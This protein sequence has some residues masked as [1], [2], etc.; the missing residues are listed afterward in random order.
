MARSTVFML[1]VLACS[2]KASNTGPIFWYLRSNSSICLDWAGATDQQ[3]QQTSVCMSNKSSQVFGLD[4]AAHRL[5]LG[6]AANCNDGSP[7]CVENF[8]G[9]SPTI[10]GCSDPSGKNFQYD[11]ASGH[12]IN[13]GCITAKGVNAG[14]TIVAC[15]PGEPNQGWAMKAAPPPPPPGVS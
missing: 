10:W 13:G 8:F 3:P 1:I 4:L 6:A 15:S 11:D 7:C 2:V 12:L 9:G 5:T 14:A